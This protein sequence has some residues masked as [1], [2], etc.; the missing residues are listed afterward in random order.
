MSNKTIISMMN[1]YTVNGPAGAIEESSVAE[2]IFS[3][4]TER[5]SSMAIF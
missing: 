2:P 5:A 1:Y 4:T 3:G